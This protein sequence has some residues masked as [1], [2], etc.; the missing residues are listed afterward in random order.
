MSKAAENA[1]GDSTGAISTFHSLS[2]LSHK[3]LW[4][5]LTL[6]RNA[7]TCIN[8]NIPIVHCFLW[9]VHLD[10]VTTYDVEDK[11]LIKKQD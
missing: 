3:D 9:T 1:A 10:Q 5:S 7:S 4:K 8:K 11:L 2:I 6:I